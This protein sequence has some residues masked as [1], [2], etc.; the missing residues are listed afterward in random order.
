[1]AHQM[2]HTVGCMPSTGCCVKMTVCADLGPIANF[3][4]LVSVNSTR[5]GTLSIATLAYRV[6][7]FDQI[8]TKKEDF[9]RIFGCKWCNS[10]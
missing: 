4:G 1:M 9:W 7:D 10:M 3:L 6:S 5:C 8:L 2:V